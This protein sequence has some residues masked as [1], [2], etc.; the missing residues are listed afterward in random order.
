MQFEIAEE[1][2]DSFYKIMLDIPVGNV[3][4][5]GSITVAF[6]PDEPTELG[7]VMIS[8]IYVSVCKEEEP[9]PTPTPSK[10]K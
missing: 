5:A 9:T 6:V 3:P 8:E 7:S 2:R 1:D 4:G 10:T